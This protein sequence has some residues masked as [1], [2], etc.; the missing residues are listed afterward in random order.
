MSSWKAAM[1]FT[2][3]HRLGAV[4]TRVE[5]SD[6]TVNR[7]QQFV[8]TMTDGSIAL[9]Q[10]DLVLDRKNQYSIET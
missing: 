1:P 8:K 9:V 7:L 5:H 6:Q 2:S 4:A 3:S 10:V